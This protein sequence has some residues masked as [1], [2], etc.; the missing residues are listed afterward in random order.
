M[1]IL[2]TGRAGQLATAL[3]E[4]AHGS[5]VELITRGRPELDLERPSEAAARISDLR[6]DVVVNAAAYTAVDRAEAEPD[7]A[8]AVNRDGATAAARA[9][10]QLGVP[11]IHISTDY[12][13]D[14]AKLAPY[15]ERDKTGP[16]NVYGTSKL[17]GEQAVLDAHPQALILRTSWV[18][19]P[20]GSNFVKTMLT[21]G[22]TRPALRVVSDQLG[23]PTSALDLAASILAI[24]PRLRDEAGGVFH[25]AGRGA[26]N[27]F[28]FA[29]AIFAES[30]KLGGPSPDLQAITTQE[31]PTP[32]RRPANSRLD[33]SAFAAR[34]GMAPRPWAEDLPRVVRRLLSA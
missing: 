5:S 16:I 9:A 3:S 25:Y 14:G 4:Q 33:C 32:A 19:S 17:A 30:R 2:V 15:V 7:R 11:F 22:A 13:F 18:F 20:F 24:A 10:A 8:F 12:V 26:T 6:P 29:E 1:R 28:G 23:S 31:Y 27:W 34:F 21:A